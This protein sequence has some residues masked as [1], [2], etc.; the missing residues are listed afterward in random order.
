MSRLLLP[1]RRTGAMLLRCPRGVAGWLAEG[2]TTGMSRRCP[3][4][5]AG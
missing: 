1:M 4:G 3:R 2:L 5:V